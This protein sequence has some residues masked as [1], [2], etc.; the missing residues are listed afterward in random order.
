MWLIYDGVWDK[1]IIGKIG[2]VRWSI[3][4]FDFNEI[5]GKMDFGTNLVTISK[6]YPNISL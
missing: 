3:V 2:T 1:I 6:E 5:N 4:I